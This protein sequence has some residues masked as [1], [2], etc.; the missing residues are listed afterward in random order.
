MPHELQRC[1]TV[2][3]VNPVLPIGIHVVLLLDNAIRTSHQR[4]HGVRYMV[5]MSAIL[6]CHP[7]LR[8]PMCSRQKG[9]VELCPGGAPHCAPV[10]TTTTYWVMTAAAHNTL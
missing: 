5:N 8:A 6:Y 10:P 4:T 1:T 2:C 7:S 9:D 3:L